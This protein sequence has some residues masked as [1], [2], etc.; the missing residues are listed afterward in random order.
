MMIEVPDL[1]YDATPTPCRLCGRPSW[2]KVAG[3]AAHP[4]CIIEIEQWGERT[5][6]ACEISADARKRR[7]LLR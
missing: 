7:S 2:V 4:C 5:C 6:K 1:V 3:V